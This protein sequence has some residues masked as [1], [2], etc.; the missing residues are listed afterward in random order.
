TTLAGRIASLVS[1]R[2]VP[3]ASMLTITFTTAAA[4]TLRSRLAAV[5][6]SVASQVDIRTFHSFGLKVI[7]AWSVDL[8]FGHVPPAV[9]GRDDTRAI[10]RRAADELGLALEPD[11]PSGEP[12]PWALCARTVDG[13]LGSVGVGG[14]AE[15][16][17]W[18]ASTS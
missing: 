6:G 17:V 18:I 8:G 1:E 11:P 3:A 7:R 12:D 15:C 10:L 16:V 5:L 2:E 9:Y 14:C 4:A 13:S